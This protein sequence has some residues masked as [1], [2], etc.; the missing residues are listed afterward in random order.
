MARIM[1]NL[2]SISVIAM[3]APMIAFGAQKENPRGV[4]VRG[5]SEYSQEVEKSDLTRRAATSVIARSVPDNKRQNRTVVSPDVKSRSAKDVVV[6]SGG[7]TRSAVKPVVRSGVT[8]TKNSSVNVSRAART[9]PVFDDVSKIGN[10]YMSCRDAYATC[11]DQ[12]CANANDTYRRCFCS[13]KFIDFREKSEKLDTAVSMLANFQDNNLNAVD[14]TAAEVKAMYTASAGEKAIKKDTSASQ[15][16]LNNITDILS[17]K[18]TIKKNTLNSLGVLDFSGFDDDGDIWDDGDAFSFFGGSSSVADLEGNALYNRAHKQCS[19]IIRDSCSNDAIYKLARSSYSLMINQDCNVVD[20]NLNAKRASL[21]ETVRTAEKYLRE[22]RLEEY[23]AHN[24][25]DV[26]ECLEKVETA[27]R[28]PVACGPN[29]EKCMDYTGRYI[30]VSTGEPIYSNA[31][32]GLNNLIVLDG[33]ADVLK[34]NSNYDKWLD[35]ETKKFAETALNSCR[36]ISAT[37]WQEFKR[38]ALIQ[39]AQAQDNKIQQVKDSC[40]ETIKE[41]YDTNSDALYDMAITDYTEWETTRGL[42]AV[43]ARST[44]YDRVLACAAL[45]G[46][47]DGCK[48]DDKTKKITNAGGNKKCGLQSLLVYVD[49]VDSVKVAEGCE[50]ALYSYAHQLCDPKVGAPA[51]DVYPMGCSTM[52]KEKLRAAMETRRKTFCPSTLVENDTSN[53]LLTANDVDA[54]NTNIMNQ[55]INDIY[56]ELGILFQEDCEDVGGVWLAGTSTGID[57]TSLNQTF[58]QTYYHTTV[59]SITD[60]NNLNLPGVGYCVVSN[61]EHD[62]T[63]VGTWDADAGICVPTTTWYANT[64]S[65]LLGGVWDTT[66]NTC[67]VEINEIPNVV[68]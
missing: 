6:N 64:C 38:S 18:T 59:N 32:F 49:T 63:A 52:P 16:L 31:L 36:D 46:D 61:N 41:C 29:Y 2:V 22:A 40:V 47:P 44:C 55:I 62:C 26:I 17:G 57:I 37:V 21:E 28:N 12:F 4:V 8:Q 10:G 33:T 7:M 30:D 27:M 53:T 51:T 50:L 19:E 45:Y 67:A 68:H 14:K 20:K 1:K 24:S 9:T 58:Y 43:A 35:K 60:V 15:K 34:A 39:I 48:Y 23:R 65:S 5:D 54:F 13:D 56:D 42:A 11:M 66:N 25:A 3:F